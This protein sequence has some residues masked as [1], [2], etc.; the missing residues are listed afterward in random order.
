MTPQLLAN[1][2]R[3][4]NDSRYYIHKNEV[5]I[6]SKGMQPPKYR[7][8]SLPEL[9]SIVEISFLNMKRSDLIEFKKTFHQYKLSIIDK[10]GCV[11]KRIFFSFLSALINYLRGYGF[12]DSI[13]L[14]SRLEKKIQIELEN[15]Y[16]DVEGTLPLDRLKLHLHFIGEKGVKAPF[17]IDQK[18]FPNI[19]FHYAINYEA[20]QFAAVVANNLPS[21]YIPKN[22][23]IRL[24]FKGKEYQIWAQEK[25]C[26]LL[27]PA[28]SYYQ[29]R[30][31]N[32]DCALALTEMVVYSHLHN[33]SAPRLA[34]FKKDDK[35]KIWFDFRNE[36]LN[37]QSILKGLT[38]LMSLFPQWAS[39]IR[40]KAASTML[41]DYDPLHLSLKIEEM[42]YLA[43]SDRDHSII[44]RHED[45]AR[46]PRVLYE[47]DSFSETEQQTLK[48]VRD[49]INEALDQQKKAFSPILA[50]E[51]RLSPTYL[52]FEALKAL[53][54]KLKEKEIIHSFLNYE[55]ACLL[56]I[57]K[58]RELLQDDIIVQF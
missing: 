14:L 5:G 57:N 29:Y 32:K 38:E 13:T 49:G 28:D 44:K 58:R 11:F 47:I 52:H 54:P 56:D 16:V 37:A 42:K 27:D 50:Y 17:Q 34:L 48:A 36:F 55:E 46:W 31:L 7:L 53:L 51:W 18:A 24:F 20:Y 23:L 39:S 3:F 26:D 12:N 41:K 33:L 10:R 45:R 19:E 21:I 8:L 40:E 15:S 25:P 35:V 2:S 4:K 43:I 9:A 6:F 30:S 1:L 22:S